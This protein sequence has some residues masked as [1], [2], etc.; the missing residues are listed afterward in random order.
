[1]IVHEGRDS[2]KHHRAS[3]NQCQPPRLNCAC[4]SLHSAAD[5]AH[6]Y[7]S[8]C[9]GVPFIY[10]ERTIDIIR[11]VMSSNDPCG[12]YLTIEHPQSFACSF[13]F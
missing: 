12:L 5:C 11:Y 7:Y 4:M 10:A 1:M 3:R 9:V 8:S 2:Y 6:Y 13:L